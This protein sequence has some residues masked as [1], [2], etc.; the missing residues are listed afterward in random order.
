MTTRAD[1]YWSNVVSAYV[2]HLERQITECFGV[3]VS[4]SS[5][6]S[7]DPAVMTGMQ[8]AQQAAITQEGARLMAKAMRVP[9]RVVGL[10]APWWR[11]LWQRH[12]TRRP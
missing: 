3:P 6:G 9:D 12:I 1:A 10:S 5:M 7:G 2:L 4:F 11:H 8:R